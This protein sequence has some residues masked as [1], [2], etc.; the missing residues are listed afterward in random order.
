MDEHGRTVKPKRGE[1][2]SPHSFRHSLAS[3]LPSKGESADEIAFMLGHA[4]AN[5][6]RAIYLHEVADAR[7]KA[8]RRELLTAASGSLVEAYEAASHLQPPDGEASNVSELRRSA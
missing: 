2:P 8:M 7:R 1:V 6:T 3:M 4:N 5:V